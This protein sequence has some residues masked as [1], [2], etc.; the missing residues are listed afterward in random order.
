MSSSADIAEAEGELKGR[1]EVCLAE[2]K[3]RNIESCVRISGE[4]AARWTL[5]L[6]D[7]GDIDGGCIQFMQG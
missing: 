7:G 3:I 6:V 5:L 2:N 4:Q 1:G